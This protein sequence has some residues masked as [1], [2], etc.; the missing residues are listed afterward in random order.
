MER[1]KFDALVSLLDDPD[2]EINKRIRSEFFAAGSDIIPLLQKE[3]GKA[4]SERVKIQIREITHLIHFTQLKEDLTIWKRDH[5]TDLLQG[6]WLAATYGFP[7]LSFEELVADFEQLY[8]EV[9]VSFHHD[10]HPLDQVEII[11]DVIFNRLEFKPDVK[12]FHSPSNSFINSVIER[13]RGNPISLCV[14]YILIG[15]KLNLPIYGVN[16]PNLFVLTYKLKRFRFYINVFNRGVTFTRQDL[17]T[18][19][20]QLRLEPQAAY[21][22]PCTELEIVSRVFRNLIISYSREEKYDK[23]EEL[24]EL[25]AILEEE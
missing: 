10:L 3:E 4:V 15:K 23:V 2:R 1:N 14:L 8:Y 12:D 25:V 5:H 7:G 22:E 11:N 20:K 21:F 19:L 17:K 24:R 18:Y 16:L 9:W 6:M 13:R